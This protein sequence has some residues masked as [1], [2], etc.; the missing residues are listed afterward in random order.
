MKMSEQPTY[1]ESESKVKELSKIKA[2]YEQVLRSL[3]ESEEKY[4]NLFHCSNDAIFIHDLDGNIIDSNPKVLELFGYTKSE[5]ASITVPMLHPVD[6]LKKSKQAFDTIIREGFVSFEIEF[7]RKNGEIFS[8]EVSSSLFKVGGQ[9]VIQGIVRDITERKLA[10]E[11]LREKEERFRGLSEAA[12][13]GIAIT[14]G[15]CFVDGNSKLAAMLGCPLQDMIGRKVSD[16]VAPESQPL[17]KKHIRTG[18]QETYE[19]LAR[20]SDGSIFPVEVRAR[21]MQHK[22]GMV[23]VTSVRDITDRKQAEAEVLREKNFSETLTSQLPGSFYMFTENGCMLRWN[24]N[25]EKVSGY[26][27]AEI[28]QMNALDFFADDEKEKVHRRIQEVFVRGASQV[29]ANFL[30]KD[31]RKIPHVLTGAR[32][33]YDGVTYLL[34]VGLDITERKRIEEAL[35]SE[36]ERLAVTLRSIGDAVIV[37]DRSGRVTLMNPIAENLTGWPET[38]AKGKPL[39]EIFNIINEMTGQPC[40]NPVQQ[41]LESGKIQGLANHTILVNRDGIRSSIADSAAPIMDAGQMIAGIVLVFRDVTTAQRT[42]AEL[43]KIEKLRSLGVLAGGIAHDFNNFLTGIIGNLSLVQLDIDPSNR[44]HPRLNEMEKAA[45]RAKNLTQQLLTFSKGGEPVK[46]IT[47]IDTLV[48]EAALFAVRG[49]NVRCQFEFPDDL[50]SAHVDAGQIGQVINNLVINADQVMPEGGIIAI[51]GKN[52]DV[53]PDSHLKL[54]PGHYVRIMIQDQGTGIKKEHLNRIYDPYFTTKQ[55]GSG[56]GLTIVYSILEK[57]EGQVLVYS[58]LGMGTTFNIYLPASPGSEVKAETSEE[59]LTSGSGR[60]LVMDDEKFIRSMATEMLRKMGYETV[61]AKG[62]AEA[63][64]IYRH[65][66]ESELPFDA[67]ILDLTIPGGMGG[68]ETM[69]RLTEIDKDVK[70]IVSSGYSNDPVISNYRDYGFFA[71][72]RKPYVIKE[73]SDALKKLK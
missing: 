15:G 51:S 35:E 39:L 8:A 57:H 5:M 37:T 28:Q 10:E 2:E 67:V 6:A 66:M 48:R 25:L 34:G 73:L 36:K 3:K 63:I 59:T 26:S 58:E 65:A 20:R 24:D 52:I 4:S 14:Q 72:V 42:E 32:L 31:G 43:L 33:E 49:S 70:A 29:E 21:V 47:Q 38:E 11:A 40:L 60:I 45:L 61:S 71:A 69:A 54:Q 56:L 1:E 23:R 13:E 19:H 53:E 18:Y 50:W 7:K 64:M 41:V 55:K 46:R 30:T 62:G 44:I 68:Q 16:F 12:L 9:K 27:G 22:E 17:V